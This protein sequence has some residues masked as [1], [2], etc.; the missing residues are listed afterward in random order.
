MFV[1]FIL[2]VCV[3]LFNVLFVLFPFIEFQLNLRYHL[4][5]CCNC[6]C[7]FFAVSFCLLIFE[8]KRDMDFSC[9]HD[10]AHWCYWILV[11]LSLLGQQEKVVP[12]VLFDLSCSPHVGWQFTLWHSWTLF[13]CCSFLWRCNGLGW[14]S[15]SCWRSQRLVNFKVFLYCRRRE[16]VLCRWDPEWWMD[17]NWV[18]LKA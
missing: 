4:F 12:L 1:L 7:I 11:W 9:R 18:I 3:Y 8:R 10:V 13:L 2:S 5:I 17:E 6:L 15:I 16:I 14:S